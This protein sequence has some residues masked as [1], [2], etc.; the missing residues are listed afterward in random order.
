MGKP[1]RFRI[2]TPLGDQRLTY[3]LEIRKK[4]ST[5]INDLPAKSRRII[6]AALERLEKDPFPGSM[7]D[8]E[9]IILRG[10]RIIFRLHISHTYTVYYSILEDRRLVRVQDIFPTEQAHK[11]YGYY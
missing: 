11:K 4:I 7:G 5:E 1:A 6:K 9:K 3:H 10:G 8:K 2:C